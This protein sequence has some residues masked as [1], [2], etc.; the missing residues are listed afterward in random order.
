MRIPDDKAVIPAEKLTHYLLVPLDEDDKSKFLAQAGFVAGNWQLLE[1]AIRDL[2]QK[3]DAVLDRT[4]V[5]GDYYRVVGTLAG[6]NGRSLEVVTVWIV[7]AQ[8]DGSFRFVTLKPYR[9]QAR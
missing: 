5:Y 7:K 9:E 3:N 1:T 4:N 8:S 6:V 2:L